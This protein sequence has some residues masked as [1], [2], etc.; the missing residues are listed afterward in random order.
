MATYGSY[1]SRSDRTKSDQELALHVKK[2][3]SPDETSPKQKHVRACIVYTWDHKTSNP[4][5][6]QLKIQPIHGD[7]VMCFKA[8]ISAHKIIRGGH[9]NTL[10][11][12]M[13]EAPF[14]ETLSRS[15]SGDGVRGY[16]TMIRAYIKLILA[17][18]EFH[19]LHRDFNG[20][21]DYE[22]YISLKGTD[23]P[24]EGYETVM[25]LMVLQDKVDAFQ[26]LVFRH[27]RPSSNNECRIAAL[28]PMVEES[29]GIYKFVMSMLIALHKLTNSE[30]ALAPL[31]QRFNAQHYALLKFYYECS[32]LKYLTS[33]ITVPKLPNDPPN[34]FDTPNAVVPYRRPATPPPPPR[35]PSP[36]TPEVAIRAIVSET[37]PNPRPVVDFW[38]EDQQKIDVVERQ[39]TIQQ[40]NLQQQQMLW[41]Q[42]MMQQRLQQ[43]REFD[44]QQ[45]LQAERERL[46]Q[47]QFAREQMQRQ[48]QG[49]LLILNENA[50]YKN[51]H[52][53][54]QMLLEQYNT[55]FVLGTRMSQM[56]LNNQARDS[57][58]DS[59]IKSLQDQLALW[60]SKYEQLAKLYQQLRQ[61]HL[62]LLGKYKQAQQR[63]KMHATEIRNKN[64]QLADMI[65]ER[66]RIKADLARQK[67]SQQDELDR[68][69]RELAQSQA[70]AEELG[71]SK[72]AEVGGIIERLISEKQNDIN[73][74]LRDVERMEQAKNEEIAILQAGMDQGLL[75]LADL[76]NASSSSETDLRAAMERLKLEHADRLSK[77]LGKQYFIGMFTKVDESIFE[78]ESPAHQGNQTATPE[79]ILTMVESVN[80]A[81]TDFA[82]ACTQHIQ[83]RGDQTEVIA[84]ATTFAQIIG[85]LLHNGK[86]VTRLAGDGSVAEKLIDSAKGTA[87]ST[88][89]FF[90]KILSSNMKGMPQSARVDSVA[91]A[92]VEQSL[93]NRLFPKRP[94]RIKWWQLLGPSKKRPIVLPHYVIKRTIRYYRPVDR[95]VHAAILDA[96][97][98]MM[99]AI[100]NLIKCATDTQQE[101]VAHGRGSSTSTE[102]YKKIIDGPKDLFRPLKQW[103]LQ[104]IHLSKRPTVGRRYGSTC[105][106]SPCQIGCHALV[107]ASQE[108]DIDLEKL[109]AYELKKR[110]LELQADILRL[111]Q[112]LDTQHR[113]L[114]EMRRYNYH[115]EEGAE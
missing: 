71:K 73:K 35:Q 27:F 65:R 2:M 55:R 9:P 20:T 103:P 88:Q 44:E 80:D 19:S 68:L 40:Q 37:E 6:S 50:N 87:E 111:K 43:Q 54:D 10:K 4:I 90:H 46:A 1:S 18:L 115:A 62:E 45:R 74:L 15:V 107:N 100:A 17:K 36:P 11:E 8:L 14:F 81:S 23:N 76:Q 85:Q 5:W 70:Q 96:V 28:V 67:T 112:E 7:E 53:R 93:P 99:N 22:D 41:Q 49:Q 33:L 83:G 109:S 60:K 89:N 64:L 106:R 3:T 47:E 101:I 86:G 12:A 52:E 104:R 42:Q 59:L 25:D 66:D 105:G 57:S 113:R 34:L 75:A 78:L 58:K 69:K 21:F 32:N 82:I 24:D 30:D 72:S 91:H 97:M 92:N 102:F 13:R 108:K 51:Q 16:G 48:S 31:R 61:E 95:S 98:A 29:Y 26:K 63:L 110:E 39:Y 56:N 84:S 114:G 79:Y 38:S 77:I 94:A